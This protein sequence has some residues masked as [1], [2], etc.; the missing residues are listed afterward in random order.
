MNAYS[1]NERTHSTMCTENDVNVA[2]F[3]KEPVY[4][5]R[6]IYASV[7]TL[8]QLMVDLVFSVASLPVQTVH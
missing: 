1:R 8:E 4:T 5:N 7:K 6:S 2:S 3:V